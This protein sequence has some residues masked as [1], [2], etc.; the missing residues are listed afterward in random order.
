[1]NIHQG[2]IEDFKLGC[3]LKKM[4]PSGV[5]HDF[6]GIFHVKNHDFTPKNLIFSNIRE[7]GGA[8]RCASLDP[9]LLIVFCVLN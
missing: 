5:R 1:M 6:L 2:R 4:A 7:E 8:R 3:A 9:P